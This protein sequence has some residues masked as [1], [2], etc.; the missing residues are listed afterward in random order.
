MDEKENKDIKDG[1]E[2]K[3]KWFAGEDDSQNE[4]KDSLEAREKS[5]ENEGDRDR[6]S[7]V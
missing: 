7:V 3:E 5:P 6:K 2:K 4:A 1:N